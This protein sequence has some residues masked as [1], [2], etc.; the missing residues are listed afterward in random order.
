MVFLSVKENNVFMWMD[1]R[2]IKEAADITNTKNA[3][4]EQMGGTCSV[5]FSLAKLFW[6]FRN[7]KDRFEKATAFMELP[8]FFAW[9]CSDLTPKDYPRS[10]CSVVCKW[11][12]DAVNKR[13]RDDLFTILGMEE[14]VR[15]KSRIGGQS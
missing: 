5:E 7:R 8:D 2:A 14:F 3:V 11:G 4:L 15:D 9:K 12:Y 1:H 13:W 10:V 6:L